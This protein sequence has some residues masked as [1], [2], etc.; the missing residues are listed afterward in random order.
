MLFF[1]VCCTVLAHRLYLVV[2]AQ[3]AW[4]EDRD[5]CEENGRMDTAD[6]KCVSSRAKK[7]GLKQLGTLGAGNHYAEI[8]VV[9]EVYHPEA[10]KTM[11]IGSV[12]QVCIMVSA[13]SSC[14]ASNIVHPSPTLRSCNTFRAD[15]HWFEGTRSSSRY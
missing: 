13:P 6:P 5:H 3:Y 12:G 1:F 9:D 7:R 8:Q 4:E 11:G 2:I 14:S 10:A 15:T